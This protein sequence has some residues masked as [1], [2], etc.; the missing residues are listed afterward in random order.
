[1]RRM[2][3]CINLAKGIGV[4][5]DIWRSILFRSSMIP[6]GVLVDKHWALLDG[7]LGWKSEGRTSSRTPNRQYI[8]IYRDKQDLHALK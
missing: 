3:W 4:G 2:G 7:F 8:C 1:M 5:I 6:V